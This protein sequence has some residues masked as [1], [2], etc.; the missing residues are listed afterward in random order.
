MDGFRVVRHGVTRRTWLLGAA[1]G[2]VAVNLPRA[3]RAAD[4][5]T[6]RLDW[7]THGIQS[8][9]FL[10]QK[11]GW[12]KAAGLEVNVEDGNG[13]A[14]TANLVGAANFDLGL[15]AIAPAALARG[16]GLPVVSVACYSRKGD[17]GIVVPK[18]SGWTKP[19]DMEGKTMVYTAGSLEGP[20]MVPFFKKNK[21]PLDKLNMLN[22][23]AA[24]K[25]NLYAAGKA[26]AC[27]TAVPFVVP[28]VEKQRPSSAILFADFGMNLPGFGFV[29]NPNQAPKKK[30]AIT[31]FVSII[32]GAW[33]YVLAGH[34]QESVDAI[35]EA[36][37]QSPVK[38]PEML[39]EIQ[40]YRSYFTTPSTKDLPLGVQTDEDWRQVLADMSSAG[41][42]PAS[43]KPS[44]IYTNDYIDVAMVKKV[45]ASG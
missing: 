43:V 42:M 27:V 33:T 19:S 4:A 17:T 20:F 24:A 39:A 5:L 9:I 16:K 13:S 18:E 40:N 31:R 10:A 11:K 45:A 15:C 14:S 12:L 34:E 25:V 44:D 37:P 36:R 8:P 38:A 21:I 22:V 29:V 35:L 32:T 26:D 41:V 28:A 7:S 1:A 6:L 2:V 3:A 30:E 23:D